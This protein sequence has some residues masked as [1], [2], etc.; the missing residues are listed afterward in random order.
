LGG[1]LITILAVLL[2]ARPP[3][4]TSSLTGATVTAVVSGTTFSG[5]EKTFNELL[6]VVIVGVMPVNGN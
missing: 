5:S 3:A 4:V 1:E 6:V 2:S